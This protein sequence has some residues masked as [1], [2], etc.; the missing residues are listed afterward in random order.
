MSAKQK[1]IKIILPLVIIAIGVIVMRFLILSRP[2]PKREARVN[3]G[4][5]VDVISV[6]KMDKQLQ[7]SGTGTVQPEQEVS[8]TMQVDGL[9][10]KVAPDF[11]AGSFFRK[12][13]LLFAVEAI[14]YEL[15]LD[16][17][18]T[19][20][21]KAENEITIIESKATVARQEWE[22]LRL[23]D[24]EEPNP[25]IVYE[26]QLEDAKAN[27]AAAIAA[28]KQAELDLQRTR[29][30][31]PFNCIVRSEEVGLGK[32]VRSG[33]SV[34]MIASVDAAEI[35]LPLPLDDLQWINIPGQKDGSKG[36][37]ATVRLEVGDTQFNWQG[38]V[39][40]S[41]GEVD[42]RSRMARLF[43]RVEDPY[44]LDNRHN[45]KN[46][47][48]EFGMFVEIILAGETLTGIV[49]VPRTALRDNS[50][51]WVMDE[52]Q[53]LRIKQ[54]QIARLEKQSALISEGLQDGDRIILTT[55]PGGV[56]GMK[57]RPADQGIT[58]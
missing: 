23:G 38:E 53:K 25:L 49:E 26:P 42:S 43:V 16:R 3:P 12:G 36:S 48:L 20:L 9:I 15:A 44:G 33:N 21:I 4:A 24:S 13:E 51:V 57:L 31:A 52:E 45:G 30:V 32:Y 47:N 19:T 10:E 7:I 46:I 35:I 54:V 1:A 28:L 56:D 8:I 22:R 55:L 41:L 5:L 17:A 18:K 11:V 29:V 58:K 2:A 40:R 34:A 50:T 14:D 27:R 37:G 6:A 39:V